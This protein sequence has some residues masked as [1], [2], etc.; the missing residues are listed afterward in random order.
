MAVNTPKSVRN[1]V[2]YEI[3]VRNHGQ[4]GNFADISADLPRIREMGVDVV[5][6]MPIHPIGQL[7]K[8]GELGCPYSI[9]DYRE[10][11]PEYGTREEFR[12]L[13]QYAH[14]LGLKVMIDV[15]FN[16]TSHD[17][18]LLDTNPDWYHLDENGR[19]TTTVPQWSDIIDLNH[20]NEDLWTYLIDSLKLWVNL[21]VDGFRCDVAS[22]VPLP[23]WQRAREE[24]AT[25]NPNVLWLA[26]SVH[27][28]FLIWQRELGKPG[29]A[30]GELHSAFDLSYDY[31]IWVLWEKAVADPE[32]VPLY[33]SALQ[34][35]K[36]IYPSHTV[37]MRCVEN[38]DQP[39]IAQRAPSRAQALAW[40]A[41]QAFNEG[42][43]LIYA[44]QESENLHTPNLFDVDKVAWNEY[45]LQRFITKLSQLKKH[46]CVVNGRLTLL[47]HSPVLTAVW[48]TE[49]QTIYGAFNVQG[50]IDVMPTPLPD[51]AH[52]NYLSDLE[53]QFEVRDGEMMVPETAVIVILDNNIELDGFQQPSIM[54]F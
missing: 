54:L 11:N 18:V 17:S 30:D 24:I 16:H 13:V 52:T 14:A 1:L 20:P 29:S 12:M 45:S 42:A 22:L 53:E 19:P 48:Q 40:T 41:F 49:T 47:T 23:F 9:Q 39:R 43:F 3:Y 32:M 50:L 28:G 31:D 8:K 15:V 46:D 37:K 35:Q 21:G 38:H 34:F 27:T 5:W 7:N 25:L 51:G 44:G 4:N 6:F 2:I 36:G 10:V 33:F 26:E